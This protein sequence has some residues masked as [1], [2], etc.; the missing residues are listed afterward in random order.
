MNQSAKTDNFTQSVIS[1][2]DPQIYSTLSSDQV[3]A[4]A[5]ALYSCRPTKKH[6][7]NFRGFIPFLKSRY[8]FVFLFG[9]DRRADL[10]NVPHNMRNA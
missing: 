5:Q 2:I 9:R 6:I 1:R 7:I 4:L 10:H 3:N 8:Y